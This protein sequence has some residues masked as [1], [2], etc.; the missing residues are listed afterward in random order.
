MRLLLCLFAFLI[1]GCGSGSQER[2]VTKPTSGPQ[3]S[4]PP[5][6][7]PAESTVTTDVA[8]VLS[9]PP[10]APDPPA[11]ADGVLACGDF[12]L[13]RGTYTFTFTVDNLAQA[14]I[15]DLKTRDHGFLLSGGKLDPLEWTVDGVVASFRIENDA[16]VMEG[17]GKVTRDN[18]VE[19]TM[20]QGPVAGTFTLE[21]QST[22][23]SVKQP[24]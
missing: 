3:R 17:K 13:T 16:N 22:S 11:D 20:K 19:G 15:V 4:T 18:Y 24:D 8:P 10:K 21:L 5:D 23:E 6:S 9:S 1:A 2:D 7:K 12:K 14:A